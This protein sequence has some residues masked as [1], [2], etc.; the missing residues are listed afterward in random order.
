M[1][2]SYSKI[3]SFRVI[4]FGVRSPLLNPVL[5]FCLYSLRTVIK[6]VSLCLPLL[7]QNAKPM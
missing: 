6:Y 7:I 5:I 4:R 3:S 2:A 1:T